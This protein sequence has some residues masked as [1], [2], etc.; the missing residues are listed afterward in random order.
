MPPPPFL[1][2][3]DD[4][5]FVLRPVKREVSALML[6]LLAMGRESRVVEKQAQVGVWM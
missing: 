3:V 6:E 5:L 1:S 2:P 4:A